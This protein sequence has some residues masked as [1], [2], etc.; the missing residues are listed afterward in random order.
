MKIA[1]YIGT[2]ALVVALGAFAVVGTTTTD[3][4]ACGGAWIDFEML[5]DFRDH[6]IDQA[7]EA[8]EEGRYEAA[9]GYII[10]VMPHVRQLKASSSP[11]VRRALRVLSV[12]T[13][14]SNGQ[15]KIDREVQSWVMGQKEWM[16]KKSEDRANNLEWAINSL[17]SIDKVKKDDPVVQTELAEALAK[18]DAHK[19]EAREILEKL[20]KKDLIVSAEGYAVLAELRAEKGDSKGSKLAMDQ[21]RKIDG[22]S[23]V[24]GTARKS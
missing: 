1:K 20:A 19:G 16:G 21:C 17:R 24:C 22:E 5:L 8:L 7:E 23:T 14:R 12:A 2:R 9:A 6:G 18:V 10:R 3:A 4:E 15:L 13:A 11:E